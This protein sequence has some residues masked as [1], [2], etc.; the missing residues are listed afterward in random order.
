MTNYII[1]GCIFLVLAFS[2][3]IGVYSSKKAKTTTGFLGAT[4]NYGAIITGLSGTAAMASGMMLCG[5]PAYIYSTGNTMVAFSLLAFCFSLSYLFLGKKMRALAEVKDIATLGDVVDARYHNNKIIK[6]CTAF[7]IFMGCFAYL[8]SQIAAGASLLTYMF[9]WDTI[10]GAVVIF[11]VVILYVVIGGESAGILSQAFQGAIM[12]TAGVFILAVF[13]FKFG[14]FPALTGAVG[15][16]ITVTG[17]NGTTSTF[18]ASMLDAFGNSKPSMA[19]VY[20][21]LP[22]IGTICQPA[23]LTRMYA[24]KDPRDLPKTGLVSGATQMVVSFTGLVIG[25]SVIYLV[26]SGKMAP[27]ANTNN[28]I[29]NLGAYLGL[30]AQILCYAAVVSA[31]ISSASMY[32][33]VA[34]SAISRD[35]WSCFGKRLEG[36]QQI[37]VSRIAICVVGIIG[38]LFASYSTQGI[39]LLAALGW[40]TLMSITLPIFVIGLVW[41]KANEKGMTAAAVCSVVLNLC[42][43]FMASNKSISWPQGMAWYTYAI[44]ISVVVGIL[45]SYF[46]Y[47]A[48]VDAIEKNVMKAMEM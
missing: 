30:G 37:R 42:G 21:M 18:S 22:L 3:L 28:C 12:F 16:S 17:S 20:I 45:G 5:I 31:I 40:G 39:A 46:T 9:G 41:K 6:G 26:S 25:Y 13:F 14:G 7:V 4:K 1:L 24:L 8:A 43:L 48:D 33:S 34:S 19:M 32:L 29:W 35:L 10:V 11:G 36:K 15:D 47:N 2:F 23:T 44:V 27:L 38:I